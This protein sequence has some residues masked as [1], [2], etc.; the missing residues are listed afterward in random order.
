MVRGPALRGMKAS[1]RMPSRRNASRYGSIPGST[2]T[3]GTRTGIGFTVS[4]RQGEWPPTVCRYS[5]DKPVQARNRITP[6]SSNN[7]T[8]ARSTARAC[9]TASSVMAQ[10]WSADVAAARPVA[11]VWRTE[12]NFMAW[13]AARGYAREAQCCCTAVLV[14]TA[15]GA[16]RTPTVRK[17]TR[18]LS[19]PALPRRRMTV[20]DKS[21]RPPGRRNR[22]ARS[23]PPIQPPLPLSA[24]NHPRA[25]SSPVR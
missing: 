14:S 5:S 25:G 1:A 18:N 6:S 8:D 11:S 23:P 21:A 13:A 15:A 16:I 3:S 22:A 10:I 9:C 2:S 12:A 4:G 19:C 24:E 20:R 7:N 17:L